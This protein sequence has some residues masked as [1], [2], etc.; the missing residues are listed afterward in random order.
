MRKRKSYLFYEWSEIP[1]DF[2]SIICL[3]GHILSRPSLQPVFMGLDTAG[4]ARAVSQI[5]MF[6]I[7]YL[8]VKKVKLVMYGARPRQG[9]CFKPPRIICH[10]NTEWPRENDLQYEEIIVNRNYAFF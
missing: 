9:P 4:T 5:P 6:G 2:R 7:S 8:W 10:P 3:S 1:A